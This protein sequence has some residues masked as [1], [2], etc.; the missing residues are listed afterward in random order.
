[1]VLHKTPSLD[2]AVQTILDESEENTLCEYLLTCAA[3]NYGLTAN[4]I[5]ELVDG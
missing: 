5:R 1:M 2:Y 3:T 4:D